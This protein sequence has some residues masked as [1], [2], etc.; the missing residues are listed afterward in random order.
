MEEDA[1]ETTLIGRLHEHLGR[2]GPRLSS[3]GTAADDRLQ[4]GRLAVRAI[5]LVAVLADRVLL[6]L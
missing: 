3:S 4:G 6:F 2:E 5:L 1:A